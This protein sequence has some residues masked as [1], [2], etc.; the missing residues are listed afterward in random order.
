MC[1]GFDPSGNESNGTCTIA[2]TA[3]GQAFR[4]VPR[5]RVNLPVRVTC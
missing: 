3:A 1:A 4:I 5:P 2:A